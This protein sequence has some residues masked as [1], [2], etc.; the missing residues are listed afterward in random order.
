PRPGEAGE[1]V[2]AQEPGGAVK[3]RI[4]SKT[5]IHNHKISE[6]IRNFATMFAPLR[7]TFVTHKLTDVRNL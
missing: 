3:E 7:Q 1:R 6:K 5:I 4:S 2:V